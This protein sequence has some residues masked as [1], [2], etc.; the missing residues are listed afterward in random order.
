MFANTGPGTKR[1]ARAP[2]FED[3]RPRDVARH[4][5]GGELDASEVEMHRFRQRL[6]EQRLREARHADQPRVSSSDD[7]EQKLL[8]DVILPHDAVRD[9]G[10]EGSHRVEQRSGI[11]ERVRGALCSGRVESGRHDHAR[12][13]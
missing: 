8:D 9:L 7:R 13:A 4:E 2:V 11:I 5:I 6:H 1:N 10:T 3:L 12:T